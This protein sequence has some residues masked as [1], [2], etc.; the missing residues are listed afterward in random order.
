M[1][2]GGHHIHQNHV[3]H[4]QLKQQRNVAKHFNIAIAK[5]ARQSIVGQATPTQHSTP[6]GGAHDANARHAQGVEQAHAKRHGVTLAGIESDERFANVKPRAVPQKV[7]PALN[8]A[9]FQVHPSV[10]TQ[11]CNQGDDSADQHSLINQTPD[12]WMVPTDH[13]AGVTQR[14][15]R[16]YCKPPLFHCALSPRLRPIGVFSP[17]LRSKISP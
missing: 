2:A 10:V 1:I 12:A 11:P 5:P 9:F 14:M 4:E 15:G 16:A 3:P 17:K 6:Q 13:G 7:E 8:A